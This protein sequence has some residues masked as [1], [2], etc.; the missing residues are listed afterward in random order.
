MNIVD[1]PEQLALSSPNACLAFAFI[2]HALA[3][4][5]V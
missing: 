4:L 5:P 2:A 1:S 3:Y